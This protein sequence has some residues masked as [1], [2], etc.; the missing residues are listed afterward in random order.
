MDNPDKAAIIASGFP[1][2]NDL[3]SALIVTLAPGA[4]T[5]VVSGVNNTTGVGFFQ[6]YSLATS[7]PELDPAPIIGRQH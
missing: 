2:E 3:E 1:P 4:Y 6:S 7:G 5:A